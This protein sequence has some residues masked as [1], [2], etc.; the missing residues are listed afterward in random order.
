MGS[1]AAP[2]VEL[3]GVL[4]AVRSRGVQVI[5]V[6]DEPRLRA[7]LAAL[8]ANEKKNPIVVRHAPDVI[9]MHDA[10]SM[11]VKQKKQSSMRVCFDMVKAGEDE[12]AVSAG[13][14]GAMMACEISGAR[15]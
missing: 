6:G 8:G 10:P 14:Q 2:R 11:A 5:L 7:E 13:K 9:P 1:A 4:A 12:A 3:E 15:R